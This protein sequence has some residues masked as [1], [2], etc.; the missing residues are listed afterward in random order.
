VKSGKVPRGNLKA[1]HLL[2]KVRLKRPKTR[3][4]VVPS[5]GTQSNGSFLPSK[6]LS[7]ISAFAR[8]PHSNRSCWAEVESEANE[9]SHVVRMVLFELPG[10]LSDSHSGP[11]LFAKVLND[12]SIRVIYFASGIFV[13]EM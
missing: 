11:P 8:E 13:Y 9:I 2:F 5:P 7:G 4:F 10:R 12:S 3:Y 1:T 6:S